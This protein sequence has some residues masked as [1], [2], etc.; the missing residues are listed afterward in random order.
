MMQ[1]S[2]TLFL[3]SLHLF[4]LSPSS[5]PPSTPISLHIVKSIEWDDLKFLLNS[6]ALKESLEVFGWV[7]EG[8][9][10][11]GTHCPM[12]WAKALVRTLMASMRPGL[13]GG[14]RGDSNRSRHPHGSYASGPF[15][16]SPLQ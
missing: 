1:C 7:T 8:L 3:P 15:T 4:I 2:V 12:V 5:F 14:N 13:Q 6:V 11:L 10:A 16:H 9:G